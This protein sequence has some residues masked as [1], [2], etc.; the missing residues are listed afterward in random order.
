MHTITLLSLHI[1]PMG[2]AIFM[3]NLIVFFLQGLR[4]HHRNEALQHHRAA[5][6]NI[7]SSTC[8]YICKYLYYV[9]TEAELLYIQDVYKATINMDAYIFLCFYIYF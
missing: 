9:L 6:V 5:E 7:S 1:V 2:N 4:N 8:V 3:V